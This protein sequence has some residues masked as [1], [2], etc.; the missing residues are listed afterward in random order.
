VPE[1]SSFEHI[2]YHARRTA[3]NIQ[4]Q[5]GD[6]RSDPRLNQILGIQYAREIHMFSPTY[7]TDIFRFYNM[8]AGI[9][10]RIDKD[11]LKAMPEH[12]VADYCSVLDYG[13]E[14]TPSL[15]SGVEFGNIFRL[16]VK[17]LSKD[18]ANVSTI[19]FKCEK[20]QVY[21]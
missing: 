3:W 6:I 12:I 16:T 14:F 2:N 1:S 17:L 8:A 19:T 18:Y 21:A 7:I 10:L 4:Q 9:M 13:A 15:L 20:R 5:N 11:E